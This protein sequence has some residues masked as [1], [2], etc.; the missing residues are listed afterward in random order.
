MKRWL[1]LGALGS[2]LAACGGSVTSDH[3]TG[4]SAGAG[5]TSGA[6]GA[7]GGSSGAGGSPV[8]CSTASDCSTGDSDH[9]DDGAPWPVDCVKGV[10]K[11]LPHESGRCWQDDH[12]QMGL[13]VGQSICPCLADCIQEDQPGYCM[14]PTQP[15]CC[16]NDYDCGDEAFVPCV[17]G[18]CK[19]PVVS[20]C[21][22]S[23]EC[24]PGKQCVG[25]TVC[26]C[27]AVCDS[28]DKPGTCL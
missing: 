24:A 19:A 10:C 3:S 14:A 7:S 5:G 16:T 27:A 22:K 11:A 28:E 18:V 26:P 8:C 25:A 6:G 20:G 2:V 9:H 4:G 15:G 17:N 12:C 23:S 13:C 21:W 1:A